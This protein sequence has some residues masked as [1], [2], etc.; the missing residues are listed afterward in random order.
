WETASERAS[1]AGIRVV[2]LRFGVILGASGGALRKMVTPF[3]F[4]L[5]GVIGTGKQ[6]WSWVALDDVVGAIEHVLAT[7]STSG[8]VNVV[9][10]QP[11]TNREFTRAL[12]RVLR[13]PTVLSIPTWA[14]RLVF[15]EMAAETLLVSQRVAP[16][17]LLNSSYRF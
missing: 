8:P 15:G 6:Y 11:V 7:P 9:S 4:C 2:H 13:R 16:T 12:G 5:G 14:A 1:R 10:P 3:Q 17:K